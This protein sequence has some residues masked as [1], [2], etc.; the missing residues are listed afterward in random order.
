LS[1]EVADG[2]PLEWHFISI[3]SGLQ[4]LVH[5]MCVMMAN[6]QWSVVNSMFAHYHVFYQAG[7]F[8]IIFTTFTYIAYS[9]FD[10][11][12]IS[13]MRGCNDNKYQQTAC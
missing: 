4:L 8:E 2:S 5:D 3:V 13:K 9:K 7:E 6:K 10:S 1:G 11:N 12:S